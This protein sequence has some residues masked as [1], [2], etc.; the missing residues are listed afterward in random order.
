MPRTQQLGLRIV[1]TTAVLC[2]LLLCVSCGSG[3][4]SSA[5]G[6]ARASTHSSTLNM[7]CFTSADTRKV[8][9]SSVFPVRAYPPERM[10]EEPWAKDFRRYI[11][12]S[13]NEGGISV[14]CSQ[15]TSSD[16]EKNKAE[17]LRKRGHNVVETKWSYAGG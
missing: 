11:G 8:V 10:L 15:V 17:E 13:G 2:G 5:A 16:A 7:L 6:S 9:V 14:T 4:S 12:Q 1:G 3:K